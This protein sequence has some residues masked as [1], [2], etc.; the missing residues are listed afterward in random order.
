M[1]R[2]TPDIVITEFMDQAAVADLAQDFAELRPNA[3]GPPRGSSPTSP[4]KGL[5]V[6]N[7]TRVRGGLLEAAPRLR[8]VG[9][10]ASG[11]TTP[12]WR[13]ARRGVEVC[14]ATANALAVAEY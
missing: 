9:A 5:I 3:G 1:A 7:R 4:G 14:P 13:P 2:A 10:S 12:T 8:V 11:S 6:R